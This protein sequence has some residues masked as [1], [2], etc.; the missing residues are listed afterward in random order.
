MPE[1]T[2]YVTAAYLI[3]LAIYGGCLLLW[4]HQG[5]QARRRLEK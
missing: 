1:Y 3:A 5:R 2:G 4:L